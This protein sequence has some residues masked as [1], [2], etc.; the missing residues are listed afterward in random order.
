MDK[1]DTEGEKGIEKIHDKSP[2]RETEAPETVFGDIGYVARVMV[3]ATLPHKATAGNEFQ[4]ENGY[5]S[6][7]IL[8]PSKVGLPYGSIPRL[9]LSWMTT[10]AV[11]T[12]SP[13][14]ELGPTLSAFMAE[15]GLTR[16]GGPKG[17]ITRLKKQIERL[18]C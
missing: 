8:A 16:S 1:K 12:R 18:V 4:R 9:L 5:Y 6:L 13:V 10:E 17:D 15:L 3:Q 2:I 7:T 14:L 11:H